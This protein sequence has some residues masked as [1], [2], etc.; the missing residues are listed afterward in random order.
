ML[1]TTFRTASGVVRVTD[2]LT[3]ADVRL[4]PLRELARRVEGLSGR[5]PMRWR[6]EPRFDYGSTAGAD[7]AARRPPFR[8][9]RPRSPSSSTAGTPARRGSRAARSRACRVDEGSRGAARRLG[10]APA[11]GGALAPRAGRGPARADAALLAGVERAAR[12][13]TA[14]GATA[15]V[16]SALALKLLVYAPSGAIV[17]APTTSL[18]ERLGGGWNWDY[19]YA[20]LRD[21]SYTLERADP[22]RL[23]RRGARVLLVADERVAAPPPRLSRC[24]G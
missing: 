23:P 2:A 16:R 13:T 11:A 8:R 7:R 17:A 22:A 10:G 4:A 3:L 24:T 18:P 5:V 9:R 12:R 1:V 6:V 20:W 14:R 15:V 19:R 21:A